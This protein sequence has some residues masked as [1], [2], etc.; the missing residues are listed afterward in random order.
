MTT[1]LRR[2]VGWRAGRRGGRAGGEA[3]GRPQR[4]GGRGDVPRAHR[5]PAPAAL[6]GRVPARAGRRRALPRPGPHRRARL[7]QPQVRPR[8]AQ[9]RRCIGGALLH[10]HGPEPN[11]PELGMAARFRSQGRIAGRG[12]ANPK[13][14]PPRACLS[15][16]AAA[17]RGCSPCALPGLGGRRCR[18]PAAPPGAGGCM[19][20]RRCCDSGVP[21]HA[22][23][24]QVTGFRVG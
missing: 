7:R 3:D 18:R 8:C 21:G 10:Y 2:V 19:A 23:S 24:P 20:G 16:K 9:F 4:A 14:A 17:A 1:W 5:P 15:D 6:R 12:V 13:C 11:L 22:A